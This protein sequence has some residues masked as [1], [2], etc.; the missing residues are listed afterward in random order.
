MSEPAPSGNDTAMSGNDSVIGFTVPKRSTRG[1]L[2]RMS[3]SLR[4]VLAAH[5]YPAPLAHLLGEA[6][7]LTVLL[8]STLRETD[9]QVTLQAQAEGG[10]VELLVCDWRTGNLRGY[11]KLRDGSPPLPAGATLADAFG[12][13]YLAI[14]LEQTEASERYQGIVPLEGKS[15]CEAVEGYFSTSEQLPTLLRVAVAR[16]AAGWVAGGLLAQHLPTGEIGQARLSTKD[17][18]DP[19]WQHVAVLAGSVSPEELTDEALPLETLLWRLLNE[20]EVRVMPAVPLAR[21]CHCSAD[22]FRTVLLRFP[23]EERAEMRN[24]DGLIVVNCEFCSKSY[25]LDI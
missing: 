17:G 12:R 13:G 23:E 7:M 25:P 2:A 20:D 10:P 24:D 16:T 15:L 1:R 22:H 4:E 19:D 3:V 18:I 5:D 9:G 6:L 21:F 14:T 11:L 8:G